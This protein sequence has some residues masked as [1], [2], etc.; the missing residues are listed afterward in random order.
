MNNLS[1]ID[2][3]TFSSLIAGAAGGAVITSIFTATSSVL[4]LGAF[5]G[6]LA[7]FIAKSSVSN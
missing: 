4:A 3:S 5:I 7:N 1:K 2:T 6:L